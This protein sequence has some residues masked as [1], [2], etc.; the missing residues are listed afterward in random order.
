MASDAS[1]AGRALALQREVKRHKAAI[2][3]HKEQLQQAA[4]ALVQVQAEC[5][6]LGI[7]MIVPGVEATHGHPTDS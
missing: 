7:R 2:R 1:L 3:Y 5:A 6:R 4:R